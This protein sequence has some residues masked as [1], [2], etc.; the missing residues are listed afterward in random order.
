LR[1]GGDGLAR[2]SEEDGSINADTG[3]Q[4]C[5]ISFVVVAVGCEVGLDA[6]SIDISVVTDIALADDAIVCLIGSAGLAGS[7]DPEISIIAVALTEFEVSV[8]A[9]VL[10]V[11]A[12]SIDH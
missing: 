10:I 8:D 2:S 3:L 5:F 11:A 6:I 7:K 9:A 12:T 1:A 4:L